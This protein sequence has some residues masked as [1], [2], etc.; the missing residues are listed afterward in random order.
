[1]RL[2]LREANQQF[3]RA[4][5]AVRAGEE[6]LL[7]ERGVPIAVIKPFREASGTEAEI[8]RLE[9]AGV[10]R[11]AAKRAPLPPWT[12]RRLRGAPLSRTIREERDVS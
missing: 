11:A 7:T 6:V 2:G 12:P 10:L 3:S 8:R 4:V 1:M 9:A 5:K